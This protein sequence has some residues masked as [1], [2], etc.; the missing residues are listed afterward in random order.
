MHIVVRQ[1]RESVVDFLVFFY[2]LGRILGCRWRGYQ[3][4]VDRLRE[5]RR[6]DGRPGAS[7]DARQVGRSGTGRR[8]RGAGNRRLRGQDGRQTCSEWQVELKPSIKQTIF[9]DRKTVVL[10]DLIRD[11]MSQKYQH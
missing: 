1:G 10:R 7:V 6:A 9:A 4:Q 2:L 11:L 5:K 3:R 8:R